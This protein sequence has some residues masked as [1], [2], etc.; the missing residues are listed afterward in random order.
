MSEASTTPDL[1]EL[2][3]AAWEAANRRDVD[4]LMGFYASDVVW[5]GS[6]VGVGTFEGAAAVRGFVEDMWGAFQTLHFEVEEIAALDNR[7]VL[8]VVRSDLRPVGS[9]GAVQSRD[10]VVYELV[11]GLTVRLAHYR[12]I[13][14]ARAAAERLA[15][16]RE[17][18]ASQTNVEVVRAIFERWDAGDHSVPTENL[19]PAVEFET[20]LSSV[21]G[22]PYRGHAG[23]ERW[24]RDI[25][26]QFAEWQFRIDNLREVG[27]AVLAIGAVLG[28]GR[29]SGIPLQFPSAIVF[30][31]RG[32]YRVTHARIYPDVNQALEAVGLS[33]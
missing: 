27:N 20:P 24:L 11:D 13:D 9:Q 3:R 16:G 4:A 19:D 26:E 5:D 12:D 7:V 2:V 18:A 1:V 30:Y 22:E 32:D 28:R 6:N 15:E 10:A 31:F 23:I 17:Q 8:A 33:E 14:A 25:D 29:A 21:S